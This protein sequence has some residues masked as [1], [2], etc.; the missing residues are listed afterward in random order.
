MSDGFE[1]KQ[2]LCGWNR[3]HRGRSMRDEVQTEE[4]GQ[5]VEGLM[6]IGRTLFFLWVTWDPLK[7]VLPPPLKLRERTFGFLSHLRVGSSVTPNFLMYH[8]YKQGP[9]LYT[10]TKPK[11]LVWIVQYRSICRCFTFYRLFQICLFYSQRIQSRS[12]TAFQLSHLF[13][14]KEF[15]ALT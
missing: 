8:F 7:V 6:V 11:K 5:V 10:T 3:G 2:G 14:L 13:S 15:F 4:R 1:K 9:L 12:H